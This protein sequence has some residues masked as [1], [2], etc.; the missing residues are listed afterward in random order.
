MATVT[1]LMMVFGSINW[2]LLPASRAT[3]SATAGKA[4]LSS[5]K[6]E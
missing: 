1:L 3:G 5:T 4:T 2:V 6:A